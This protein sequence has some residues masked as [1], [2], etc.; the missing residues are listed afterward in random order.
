[1]R[2]LSGTILA[3][4]AMPSFMCLGGDAKGLD[5][6]WRF[7]RGDVAEEV[8]VIPGSGGAFRYFGPSGTGLDTSTLSGGFLER[9]PDGEWRNI[10]FADLAKAYPPNAA[11]LRALRD[12]AVGTPDFRRIRPL[13][14][15]MPLA[16]P[17]VTGWFRGKFTFV[18]HVPSAEEWPV[19]FHASSI[20]GRN[21]CARV[22]VLDAAGTETGS[23]RIEGPSSE[24]NVIQATEAGVARFEVDCGGGLVS[25]ESRWSGQGILA[26]VYAHPF[27]GRNRRFYFA[28][29]S[30]ATMIFGDG[31]R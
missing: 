29:P 30:E 22:K 5:C 1:M 27:C 13:S 6:G 16:C 26:D 7:H 21:F 2:I 9:G 11:A 8:R 15:T 10:V 18:Q 4:A 28:V 25:V 12:F 31:N 23:F 24:T 14:D 20:L 17:A 3:L 19:V